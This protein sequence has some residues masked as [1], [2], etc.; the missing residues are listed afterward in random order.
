MR[1]WM[2]GTMCGRGGSSPLRART[3]FGMRRWHR[4]HT[5]A[6][7]LQEFANLA[8]A[9]GGCPVAGSYRVALELAL[10]F[11]DG[12]A[13]IGDEFLFASVVQLVDPEMSAV[14]IEQFAEFGFGFTF[15]SLPNRASPRPVIAPACRIADCVLRRSRVLISVRA[16]ASPLSFSRAASFAARRCAPH[17]WRRPAPASSCAPSATAE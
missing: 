2:S 4:L 15:V 5:V 1:A 14:A 8:V 10:R 12:K 11:A 6:D 16:S 9:G 13:R 3:S 17:G 7:E